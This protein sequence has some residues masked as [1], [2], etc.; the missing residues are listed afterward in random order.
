MIAVALTVLTGNSKPAGWFLLVVGCAV[1]AFPYWQD[2]RY[3]NYRP[4]CHQVN[5]M[6]ADEYKQRL[7]DPRF[8]RWVD[9]LFPA[10]TR[11]KEVK[12]ENVL[13]S[14]RAASGFLDGRCSREAQVSIRQVQLHWP[15]W[16]RN[17]DVLRQEIRASAGYQLATSL[18]DDGGY[19]VVVTAYISCVESMIV[20]ERVASVA[21]IFGTGT[22]TG[23]SCSVSSNEP[24]LQALLCS[25]RK[26]VQCGSDIYVSLDQYM[27]NE[28]GYIFRELSGSRKRVLGR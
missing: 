21:S 1:I 3:G 24:T 19:D 20:G 25:G 26:G 23:D 12:G 6:S 4:N 28:G 14:A 13:P 17:S 8:R 10:P 22:C 2:W 27:S 16:I 15:S 9:H 5:A 11:T 18:T 7:R